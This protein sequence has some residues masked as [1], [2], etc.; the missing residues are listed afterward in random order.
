MVN[1]YWA[2]SSS[3]QFSPSLQSTVGAGATLAGRTLMLAA[4]C[5]LAAPC[6]AVQMINALQY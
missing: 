4:A 3:Q 1:N 6:V 5:M 2:P